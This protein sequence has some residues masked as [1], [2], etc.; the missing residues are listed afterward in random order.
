MFR[1]RTPNIIHLLGGDENILSELEQ[2]HS[3]PYTPA[4]RAEDVRAL[5]YNKQPDPLVV[6]QHNTIK[7]RQG[8]LILIVGTRASGLDRIH[9]TLE[10]I[11]HNAEE[12]LGR[13]S[14]VVSRIKVITP[15]EI[16]QAIIAKNKEYS[17]GGLIFWM[18]AREIPD[19]LAVLLTVKER[20]GNLR[21][22]KKFVKVV[23]QLDVKDFLELQ[24]RSN[25][26]DILN[27]TSTQVLFLHRWTKATLEDWYHQTS[28]VPPIS[29]ESILQ[30]TGG[31]DASIM[32]YLD[33]K[34]YPDLAQ[35]G[36]AVP[37][38][39]EVSAIVRALLDYGDNLA[40][41]DLCE[42][43]EITS[44]FGIIV[45]ILTSSEILIRSHENKLSLEPTIA[46]ALKRTPRA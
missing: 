19:P 18:D 3:Q 40:E 22:D 10:H 35:L 23:C 9:D 30:K 36:Y 44:H 5:L 14:V 4:G 8:G 43:A 11:V 42:M 29:M 31:W 38:M 13:K 1:L 24:L 25:A 26:N 32:A 15:V 16:R 6:S 41:E 34:D 45:E 33:G 46:S 39:P 12:S 21:T 17:E 7:F 28:K 37:D 27:S 20:L 2:F